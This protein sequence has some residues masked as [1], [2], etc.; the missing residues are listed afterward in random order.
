VFRI[1]KDGIGYAML[2]SFTGNSGEG[3]RPTAALVEGPDG[4][5]YGTTPEGGAANRGTVFRLNKDGS[6]HMV[7][8][9]FTGS[10]GS[11]PGAALRVSSDGAIYGTASGGGNSGYGTLFSLSVAQTV[12]CLSVTPE[13]VS[14]T[15]TGP[16]GRSFTI[17]RA[18]SPNGPWNEVATLPMP[19][20]G[21]NE[22]LDPDPLPGQA[23]YRTVIPSEGVTNYT[24]RLSFG[25][26]NSE[27]LCVCTRRQTVRV[28]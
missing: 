5:L 27:K 16:P 6:G 4:A 23:F 18:S 21:W 25:V 7:L 8:W 3:S 28:S 19:F 17:E 12:C 9:H 10:D 13:G 22:F 15:L 1:N 24:R 14:F 11:S 20:S 2:R 26:T